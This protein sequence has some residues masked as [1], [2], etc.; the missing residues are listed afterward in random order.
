MHNKKPWLKHY[1]HGVPDTINPDAYQSLVH[2]FEKYADDFSERP[3]FVNSGV[4]LSYREMKSLIRDF[5]GFLQLYLKLEPG[6][7]LAIMMP[8]ILQYPVAIFGAQKAGLII[9]NVNPLYTAPEL[10][11]QLNDS[12]A[13]V[14]LVL[15]NF[16]D[17]VEAIINQTKIKHIIIAKIGDLLGFWKGSFFNL[18]ARYLKGLVPDYHLP[19]AIFFKKALQIG[20]KCSFKTVELKN[21]DIAFLQ[22]T[23]GTTGRSKGAILTHRNIIANVMQCVSWIKDVKA[24]HYGIMVGALPMYHIFSLTVCG[25][26]IFP[27][28]ASTIL[29]TNPRDTSGFIKTIRKCQMTMVV[30]LNTLFNSLL[31]HPKFSLVDFSRLKLTISGGMAMQKTVADRWQMVSGVPVLEGYGLTESSPV[32]TLCPVNMTHF[33]GSVGVPVPSTDV[34]IRDEKGSD[35]PFHQV[36]EI[37][38]R[39]PQVMKGYWHNDAETQNVIDESGWLRTGDIGYMDE[40][41]FVYIVDRKKDMVVV[42]GFNVYPNEVEAV[43]S[44]HPSIQAVAVIGIPSAKTGEALKAFIIKKDPHLTEAELIAYC[45]KS[46]TPYKIPRFF[47][48]RDHLPMSPVGKVLRR[49]LKKEEEKVT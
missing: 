39:G 49:E 7:R 4:S 20:K 21:S 6:A 23:G 11:Q 18:A 41:G 32:L 33:T 30:G 46:L 16:A 47:E 31:N 15:E 3:V 19:K 1:T 45:R 27:M 34:V 10:C 22:Y 35:L 42:S 28:G 14:I 29:I 26:C 12:K 44:S 5:A 17:R 36:G 24:Q 38:G 25:V 8:N 9:V 13:E 2:L 37:W 48:F 43:I 40:R